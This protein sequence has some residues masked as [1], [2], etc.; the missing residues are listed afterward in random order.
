MDPSASVALFGADELLLQKHAIERKGTSVAESTYIGTPA[1]AADL[2][3]TA[4]TVR[5]LVAR[6]ELPAIRIGGQLRIRRDDYA[7]FLR[8]PA[9]S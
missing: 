9:A 6:G 1:I 8:A 5:N 7:E 3:V 4:Q 2:D